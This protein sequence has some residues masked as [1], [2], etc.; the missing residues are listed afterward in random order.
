MLLGSL[1]Y[2][3]ASSPLPEPEPRVPRRPDILGPYYQ[4]L[5]SWGS[6]GILMSCLQADMGPQVRSGL[7]STSRQGQQASLG[8]WACLT[9]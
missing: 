2:G 1:F 4:M 6:S 9:P 7:M 8:T 3:P 5:C